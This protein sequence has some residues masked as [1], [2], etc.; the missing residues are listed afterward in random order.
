M[1]ELEYTDFLFESGIADIVI[2]DDSSAVKSQGIDI[3]DESIDLDTSA[4][5]VDEFFQYLF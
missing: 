4:D 5:V 3:G 2:G 1:N